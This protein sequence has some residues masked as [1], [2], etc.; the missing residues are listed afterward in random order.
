MALKSR[1]GKAEDLTITISK[2]TSVSPFKRN[3]PAEVGDGSVSRHECIISGI[4]E[5]VKYPPPHPNPSC[6]TIAW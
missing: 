4:F 1:K 2:S 3:W 6:R 5:T